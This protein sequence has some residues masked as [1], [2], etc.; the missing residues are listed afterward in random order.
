VLDADKRFVRP[1]RC[2]A[3]SINPFVKGSAMEFSEGYWVL[4]LE[5]T[6]NG[7]RTPVWT[8]CCDTGI[9]DL[10]EEEWCKPIVILD[11]L[12]ERA[13]RLS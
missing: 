7:S 11:L 8:P 6:F 4:L 5:F 9:F 13:G 12:I 3:R 2:V 1:S 10:A